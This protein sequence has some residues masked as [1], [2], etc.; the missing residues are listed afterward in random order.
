MTES[1]GLW[2]GLIPFAVI[3]LS[4]VVAII[5]ARTLT[6][7]KSSIA[8]AL[9]ICFGW[10]LAVGLAVGGRQ[11]WE[12]FPEDPWRQFLL[13]IGLVSL[14]LSA[15]HSVSNPSP[16]TVWWR[17]LL[18]ALGS[19]LAGYAI[20]PAGEGWEDT[21][22]LHR[23]W[24][25]A[26]VASCVI[27]IWSLDA[28]CRRGGERWAG[29]VSV[30]GLAGVF[31]YAAGIY[32]GLAEAICAGLIAAIV[33][34][35]LSGFKSLASSS[36]VIYPSCLFLACSTAS[37]R[38]YS[39]ETPIPWVLG[40]ILLQPALICCADL[41]VARKSGLTRVAIAA[42]TALVILAILFWKLNPMAEDQS[43]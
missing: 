7:Q 13:P 23:D 20:M 37:A 9:S 6:P 26:V 40:L 15:L 12:L 22:P 1:I 43:W 11:S 3:S 42:I 18:A 2:C 38:F 29:W 36:A 35:I 5:A 34:S 17:G 30:A 21:V 4:G 39:Y 16:R 41:A 27:N 8:C 33:A 14:A 24:M 32:G 31:L 10:S 25:L 19:L 28:L